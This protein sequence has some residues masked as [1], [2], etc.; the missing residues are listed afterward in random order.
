MFGVLLGTASLFGLLHVLK[1]PHHHGRRGFG[2]GGFGRPGRALYWFLNELD[3]TPGQEKT[4]RT[5]VNDVFER[6]RG[7][8]RDMFDSRSALADILAADELDE[9]ALDQLFKRWESSFA[10]MSSVM[11]SSLRQIHDVLDPE[12]RERLRSLVQHLPRGGRGPYRSCH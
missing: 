9:A 7:V 6:A 11:V 3:T 5:A 2:R 10:E 1:H 12:Q 4:I 8:R